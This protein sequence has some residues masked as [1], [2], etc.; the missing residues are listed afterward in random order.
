MSEAVVVWLCKDLRLGHFSSE[1]K[2]HSK[3]GVDAD[4]RKTG[5]T[6]S[7][8]ERCKNVFLVEKK[9]DMV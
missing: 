4:L 8:L 3:S 7:S 9:Q 1:E 5:R 2:T 6:N